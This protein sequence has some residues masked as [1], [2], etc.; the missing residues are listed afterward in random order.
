M[1]R[2]PT[3]ADVAR[4]AGVS[5]ATVDRVLNCRHP[6]RGDTAERVVAAAAALGYH[7]TALLQQRINPDLPQCTFGFLLQR[8]SDHF[9]QTLAGALAEAARLAT[10]VR[11]RSVIE[12][13]D[14]LAPATAVRGIMALSL[15]THAMAVVCADHPHVSEAIADART[16]GVPVVAMLSDLTAP[17]RAGYVGLDGRKAGRTAAWMV[18]R[19]RPGPIGIIVGSHRFLGHEQCE[20]GFRSYFREHAPAFNLLDSR[21][22]LDDPR[23]AE[24]ATREILG[25]H[26]DLT[27]I[28]V[29][30]GGMDGVIGA[31]RDECPATRVI[32]VCNELSPATRAGLIDGLVTLALGTP[33]DAV[34]SQTVALLSSALADPG[35]A[36]AQVFLPFAMHVAENL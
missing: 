30:G 12:F 23:L 11:G 29:A 2:R 32:L 27:G 31:L 5:V 24:E 26:A 9:Y 22:N 13:L 16:R 17:R 8:R 36:P 10:T 3:I 18:A 25:R 4:A 21:L 34:A 19:G 15:R 33:V 28:Y 14:D 20:I 35:R 7:A 1:A 6:V